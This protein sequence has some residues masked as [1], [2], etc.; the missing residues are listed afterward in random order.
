MKRDVKKMAAAGLAV[1]RYLE[2]QKEGKAEA[3][4]VEA[5]ASL[6]EKAPPASALG[7]AWVS[8]GRM[9]AMQIRNLMQYRIFQKA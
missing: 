4:L 5:P 9:S 1:I 3:P 2:S 6:E 8:S 7:S